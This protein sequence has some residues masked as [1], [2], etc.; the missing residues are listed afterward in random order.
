[1]YPQHHDVQYSPLANYQPNGWHPHSYSYGNP[2]YHPPGLPVPLQQP[3]PPLAPTQPHTDE[4]TAAS[5]FADVFQLDEF[6]RGRL[7]PLPGYQSRPGLV[8]VKERNR[9]QITVPTLPFSAK[10]YQKKA[11]TD[12]ITE[13]SISKHIFLNG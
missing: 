12:N 10:N 4:L 1:M 13:V 5:S 7:A 2:S 3:P 9:I 6:W 8:P 11:F